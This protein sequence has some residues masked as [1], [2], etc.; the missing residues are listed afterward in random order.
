MVKMMSEH[1][2]ESEGVQ[3]S[4]I[5]ICPNCGAD[6]FEVG[7]VE[8]ISGG[9]SETEI[10]FVDG[11]VKSGVTETMDFDE[12][13]AL[14]S[15]CRGRVEH[16]AAAMIEAFKELHPPKVEEKPAPL[17][18]IEVKTPILP[19]NMEKL[20]DGLRDFLNSKGIDA[21]IE[22]ALTGNTTV[23]KDVV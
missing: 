5:N 16:T 1:K 22:S 2:E 19:E 12:Q 3:E 6:L 7:V 21:V 10:H 8:A 4:P 14:C 15:K 11:G 20:E 17:L 23:T 13:W 18:T 9:Y